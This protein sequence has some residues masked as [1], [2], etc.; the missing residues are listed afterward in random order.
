MIL[1]K[2]NK[3]LIYCRFDADILNVFSISMDLRSIDFCSDQIL[4]DEKC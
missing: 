4:E 2:Y 1:Y 3:I